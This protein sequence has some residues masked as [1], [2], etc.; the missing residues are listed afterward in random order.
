MKKSSSKQTRKVE[1]QP[2]TNNM[3]AEASRWE[4]V[5]EMGNHREVMELERGEE[6]PTKQSVLCYLA[7]KWKVK[8]ENIV[9]KK[10]VFRK[11]KQK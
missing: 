4:A 8:I 9:V 10:I 5:M 6:F 11:K 7:R 2:I 1:L 3:I